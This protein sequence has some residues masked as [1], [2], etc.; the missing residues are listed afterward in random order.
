M[1]S[2][3][4]AR[5]VSPIAAVGKSAKQ[6]EMS[7]AVMMISTLLA[8]LRASKVPSSRRNV[9]RFREA[10]LQD[11]LSSDMYALRSVDVPRGGHALAALGELAGLEG[12]VLAQERHQVQGGEVAGRVVQRHVLA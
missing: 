1:P 2:W 7:I 5:V 3:R 6:S 9:I 8:N 11:E 10:R 12:A 4:K